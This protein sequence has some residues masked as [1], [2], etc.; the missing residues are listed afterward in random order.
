MLKSTE[1]KLRSKKKGDREEKGREG[2]QREQGPESMG[3][4]NSH[5]LQ[6]PSDPELISK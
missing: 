4:E 1:G 2:S 6:S 3:G 5:H